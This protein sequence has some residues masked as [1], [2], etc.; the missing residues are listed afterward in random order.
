MDERRYV[1]DPDS[2][3]SVERFHGRYVPPEFRSHSIS[4]VGRH[5]HVLDFD[6]HCELL[7]Y[8]CLMKCELAPRGWYCTRIPLHDG[9]CA[10]RPRGWNW[11]RLARIVRK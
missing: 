11:T 4:G 2:R 1:R 5:E 7:A 6:L 10:A 9:P 8:C 3:V